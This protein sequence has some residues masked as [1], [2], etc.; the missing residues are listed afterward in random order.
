MGKWV[1][2]SITPPPPWLA[3]Q[4]DLSSL[5]LNGVVKADLTGPNSIDA[6]TN[7]LAVKFL[8]SDVTL[9]LPEGNAVTVTVTGN[10]GTRTLTG[11][12]VIT[13]K[14][15]KVLSPI[16]GA[17]RQSGAPALVN[18]QVPK[19]TETQPVAILYSLDHGATWA[20]GA[21]HLANTGT[22]TAWVAP[23]VT[24]DSVKVAVAL[25]ESGDPANGDFQA[26]LAV[27]DYFLIAAGP[28]G[29]EDL[30]ATL[31]FAPVVPNPSMAGANLRFGLPRAT[32]VQIQVFDVQGRRVKTLVNT[33][34]PAG[35]HAVHWD[36]TDERGNAVGSGLYFLRMRAEGRTFEQRL[37]LLR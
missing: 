5:R 24:N 29:V 6:T 10:I 31:T 8:R 16:A 15:G 28:A 33:T 23:N 34:K 2:G 36:A 1:T 13:V 21:N 30:P 9:A 27:S 20:I 25:V 26:V 17:Y 32:G 3:S 35:W 11:S 37:T 4:I 19:G 22:S 14:H 18:W 7:T 12:D